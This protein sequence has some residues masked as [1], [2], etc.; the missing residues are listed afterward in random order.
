M[1]P[2]S[3]SMTRYLASKRSVDDR[4]LNRV[5]LEALRK[6]VERLERK[7]VRVLELGAGLGTMMPRLWNWDVLGDAH[8]TLLDRDVEILREAARRLR[9][10][11]AGVGTAAEHGDALTIRSSKG[12]LT[13]H[14]VAAELFDFLGVR[15]EPGMYELLIANAV[16]DLVDV[17]RLLPLL[18]RALVPGGLA[19]LTINFDGETV[20]LPELPFDDQIT[21]LYH[22]TMDTRITDGRPAG[23]SKT[24]RRLLE[25][26]LKSGA[27]VLCAGSSDWV[28]WPSRRSYPEDEEYFLHE[29]VHT[30]G[31]ALRNANEL[32]R[33]ALEEW[34]RTRHEQATEGK[35]VYIA[36]QI[37]V[38]AR[39][40]E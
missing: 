10:W 19:W 8:Y 16:L 36:H 37:D 29:I 3:Y 32:D 31:H 40:P 30:I 23:D 5:V 20:L 17:P 26:L 2:T 35:L 7:P 6:Q 14:F 38:L 33:S 13:T 4:S 15:T 39:T 21:A 12:A 34:T 18:W 25:N 9:S 28:I 27:V 1:E 11:G 22:R 24:G